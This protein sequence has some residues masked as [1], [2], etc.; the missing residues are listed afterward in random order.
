MRR[1]MEDFAREP[2]YESEWPSRRASITA[3]PTGAGAP[4]STALTTTGGQAPFGLQPF[5]QRRSPIR[6]D[7]IESPDAVTVIAEMPGFNKEDIRVNVDENNVLEVQAER[8]EERQPVPGE[9]YP[10]R[11]LHYGLFKR[12]FRLPTYADPQNVQTEFKNGMLGIK[13]GRRQVPGHQQITIQ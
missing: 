3:G 5:R 8:R 6:M 10:H 2:F 9:V 7:L 1:F 13:F 12:S 4:G 11:E